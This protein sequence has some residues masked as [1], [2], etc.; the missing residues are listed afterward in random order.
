MD[1]GRDDAVGE[2]LQHHAGVDDDVAFRRHGVDPAA[3]GLDLEAGS[4]G[5]GKRG[6]QVD[7]AVLARPHVALARGEVHG[8]VVDGSGE[9]GSVAEHALE[10]VLVAA[11]GE[12]DDVQ[13]PP[14]QVG[15][16]V[17]EAVEDGGDAGH[18]GLGQHL[19]AV[20]MRVTGA[21]RVAEGSLAAPVQHLLPVG[22]VGGG[23]GLDQQPGV[24]G[25]AV[26]TG[27]HESRLHLGRLREELGQHVVGLIQQV[28]RQV[29]AGVDEAGLQA[30][31]H[32]VDHRP[33]FAAIA[34]LEVQEIHVEDVVGHGETLVRARIG[35]VELVELERH[36][37]RSVVGQPAHR[38]AEIVDDGGRGDAEAAADHDVVDAPSGRVGGDGGADARAG[39]RPG[40]LEPAL[41]QHGDGGLGRCGVEV[42]G[43]DDRHR[44]GEQRGH[45]PGLFGPPVLVRRAR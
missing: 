39:Q 31:P 18:R 20:A 10:E 16:G 22:H 9:M 25:L 17:V 12:G 45:V 40:I 14:L 6:D 34:L 2:L 36:L 33:P 13:E 15:D 27:G 4:A 21:Q 19:V 41:Q 38:R 24:A 44:V 28:L 3:V 37:D 1:A 29:V 8:R 26:R 11:D 23:G 7:V 5:P 42:A 35:V 32:P 43:E 30:A